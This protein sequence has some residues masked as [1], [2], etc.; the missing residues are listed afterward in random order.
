[1]AHFGRGLPRPREAL[2]A[3]VPEAQPG[4]AGL[5]VPLPEVAAV[6]NYP[7]QG[8]P[9]PGGLQTTS[10][11][12]VALLKDPPPRSGPGPPNELLLGNRGIPFLSP[13]H[14][15]ALDPTTPQVGAKH[16][17]G[18]GNLVAS[19][20]IPTAPPGERRGC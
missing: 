7:E 5:F 4:H 10:V 15:D 9:G 14:P 6:E 19:P 13:L 17:G 20:K 18:L 11:P 8:W 2:E 12:Q 16:P 3:Q 1:M